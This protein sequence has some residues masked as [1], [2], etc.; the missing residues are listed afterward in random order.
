MEMNDIH[1][2][3]VFVSFYKSE[4]CRYTNVMF[5]DYNLCYQF[6][7]AFITISLMSS[8]FS[9]PWMQ[10]LN[11]NTKM[12]RRDEDTPDPLRLTTRQQTPRHRYSADYHQY[13]QQ[14]KLLWIL[15]DP[16]VD[17]TATIFILG[18]QLHAE[19]IDPYK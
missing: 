8:S 1:Y 17:S 15:I 2:S 19:E 9:L 5:Y 13:K 16:A 6:P 18:Q 12:K 14:S 11:L 10:R 4:L 3:F 7:F